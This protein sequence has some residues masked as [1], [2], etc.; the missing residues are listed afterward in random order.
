MCIKISWYWFASETF[1][2]KRGRN[3]YLL[4]ETPHRDAYRTSFRWTSRKTRLEVPKMLHKK[5][6]RAE[7]SYTASKI[8]DISTGQH[9]K[10]CNDSQLQQRKETVTSVR[11]VLRLGQVLT[12]TQE[13]F[14]KPKRGFSY[15]T[16]LRN[17]CF[18]RRETGHFL[19]KARIV[20]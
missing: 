13:R 19:P 2:W 17:V 20:Q 5:G 16:T 6:S 18:L 11:Q 1:L 14:F 15:K 4:I 8:N 12:D 3:M 7:S 9:G 10:V